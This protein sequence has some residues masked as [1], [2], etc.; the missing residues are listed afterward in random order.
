MEK[1]IFDIL[2]YLLFPKKIFFLKFFKEIFQHTAIRN[3]FGRTNGTISGLINSNSSA[4]AIRCKL[5][6]FKK[7]Q[8]IKN[9]RFHS[10]LPLVI[11]R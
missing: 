9:E 6:R 5:T 3:I 11:Y 10:I 4:E 2:H 7:N 8:I 1:Y